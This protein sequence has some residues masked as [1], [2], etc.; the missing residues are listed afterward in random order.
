MTTTEVVSKHGK[1]APQLGNH[2]GRRVRVMPILVTLAAVAFAG[3]LG[4]AAWNV[5]IRWLRVSVFP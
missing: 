5:Y 4:W 1:L 3:S 2:A